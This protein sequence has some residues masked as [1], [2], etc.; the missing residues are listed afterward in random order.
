MIERIRFKNFKA[1]KDAE[2]K[3]GGFNL[4]VGPNAQLDAGPAFQPSTLMA[5]KSVLDVVGPF[6]EVGPLQGWLDW[7]MRLHESR[8]P[9]GMVDELVTMRRF[10]DDN[11]SL[12]HQDGKT[13]VHRFLHDSLQ[14]RRAQ[15]SE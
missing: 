5:Y 14:R 1:L 4:I 8:L 6:D 12:R 13:E 10:H 9:T 7:Y 3:L 11:L 15:G 2:V